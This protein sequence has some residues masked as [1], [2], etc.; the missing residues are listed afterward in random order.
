MVIIPM[1]YQTEAG[2]LLGELTKG[3][4]ITSK[5]LPIYKSTLQAT[6]VG[7]LTPYSGSEKIELEQKHYD[8]L[9]ADY[10]E[11]KQKDKNK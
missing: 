2:I 7:E 3:M 6:G 8:Y 1:K 9:T 11:T 4:W 10:F 5:G